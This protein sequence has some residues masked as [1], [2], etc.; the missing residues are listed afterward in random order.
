MLV[1]LPLQPDQPRGPGQR[2]L[3]QV[4]GAVGGLDE[5]GGPGGALAGDDLPRP[6]FLQG[7]GLAVPSGALGRVGP[8]RPPRPWILG[9]VPDGFGAQRRAVLARLA[10]A[11]GLGRDGVDDLRVG[12]C[13]A[14]PVEVRLQIRRRPA[15]AGAD[16]EPQVRLVQ[17]LE[18]GRQEHAG[19]GDDDEVGELVPL[20]EGLDDR[21]QRGRLGLVAFEAADLQGEPVPVDQQPHHDLRIDPALF[22]VGDFVQVIFVFGLEVRRGHVVQ[23]QADIAVG[24]RVGEAGRRELVPV[25]PGVAAA[26]GAL[27]SR[28]AHR[29]PAQ[30]GQHPVDVEQ[31][32][33][34]L[35]A[36]RSP[37]PGGPRRPRHRSP[38][39]RT[40]RASASNSNPEDVLSTRAAGTVGGRIGSVDGPGNRVDAVGA[41]TIASSRVAGVMPRSNAPWPSSTSS[42]RARSISSPSS[43]S[44]RAEPTCRTI[45]RRSCTDSAI[46]TA[47]A[48]E[49]VR[50]RRIQAT[51]RPTHGQSMPHQHTQ[52]SHHRRSAR[53]GPRT[54]AFVTQLRPDTGCATGHQPVPC[55]RAAST[56]S[57]SSCLRTSWVGSKGSVPW[58]R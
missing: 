12:A 50:T 38:N 5:P 24:S 26:Q 49:A 54:T 6:F 23:A 19:I 3:I 55:E 47:V 53:S 20:A 56:R 32:G 52:H 35:D 4:A 28:Q 48:P 29:H 18:V 33:R 34:L 45:R 2:C 8:H 40:P 30:L 39:R 15:G 46:C 27:A 10:A 17:C 44:S 37:G 36:R 41:G 9:G 42:R 1:T 21:D 13:V 11:A 57:R 16:D 25:V 7:E 51:I 22:G 43:A 58:I 14:V 31:A